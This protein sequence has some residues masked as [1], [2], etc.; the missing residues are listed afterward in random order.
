MNPSP[1]VLPLRSRGALAAAG[2]L[3]AAALL[4]PGARA[5]TEATAADGRHVLLKDDGTW[6]YADEKTDK[7]AS[8]P[9]AKPD[10]E[11]VLQLESRIDLGRSCRFVVSLQNALPYEIASLVPYLTAYRSNGASY[12]TES[13]AFQSIR[14]GNRQERSAEFSGIACSDVARL[15]VGGGNR[16][17]MGDLNKFT[18]LKGQ[19]LARIR[20]VA[21]ELLHFEK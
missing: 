14:P 20:V 11:A 19:C 21:S 17:E 12:Q 6:R 9:E 13:L 4:A 7:P 1:K 5:D 8:A 18:E 15:Q 3:A 10:G 16:C 2:L